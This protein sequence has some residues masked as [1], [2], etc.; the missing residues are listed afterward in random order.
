[1][2]L[3]Y[4]ELRVASIPVIMFLVCA[5]AAMMNMD[6]AHC[7]AGQGYVENG[8]CFLSL[9][10]GTFQETDASE[11]RRIR[12]REY[13]QML[14]FVGMIVSGITACATISWHRQWK[15]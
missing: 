2:K 8:R 7:G 15:W 5:G 4:R 1:M 11:F 13:I 14:A 10:H 12:H 3:W 6:D 9:G